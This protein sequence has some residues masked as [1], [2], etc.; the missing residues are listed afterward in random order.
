MF[1]P[2]IGEEVVK[3]NVLLRMTR[4]DHDVL[5]THSVT[6]VQASLPKIQGFSIAISAGK[7]VRDE[8]DGERLQQD[9][10]EGNATAE[11]QDQAPFLRQQVVTNYRAVHTHWSFCMREIFYDHWASKR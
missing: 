10:P 5:L 8:R 1:F 11:E 6:H 9:Q 7:L 3:I 2:L 4:A